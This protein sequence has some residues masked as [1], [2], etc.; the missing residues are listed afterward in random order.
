[1]PV[2]VSVTPSRRLSE[3]LSGSPVRSS[4][5]P[6]GTV[7]SLCAF[8]PPVTVLPLCCPRDSKALPEFMA[9]RAAASYAAVVAPSLVVLAVVFFFIRVF[10][11]T[12]ERK[13]EET[14]IKQRK[15]VTPFGRFRWVRWR[16]PPPEKPDCLLD[17]FVIRHIF[18]AG[19]KASLEGSM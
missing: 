1:M 11:E 4:V 15:R 10:L 7:M 19:E 16:I 17:R 6:T 2:T 3:L 18:V 12:K 9:L 13:T 5:T 14:A 8:M